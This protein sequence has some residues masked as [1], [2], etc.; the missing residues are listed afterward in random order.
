MNE[1]KKKTFVLVR[2]YWEKQLGFPINHET[3]EKWAKVEKILQAIVEYDHDPLTCRH[4]YMQLRYPEARGQR[5]C[6]KCGLPEIEVD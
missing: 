6:S 5:F 4:E 1:I 3:I 2:D